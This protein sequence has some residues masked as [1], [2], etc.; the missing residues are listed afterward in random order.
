VI[1]GM[2]TYAAGIFFLTGW[3]RITHEV[4]YYGLFFSLGFS[5]SVGMVL[6]SQIKELFDIRMS[7]TAMTA[8]NFFS[9]MGSAVCMQAMG[10]IIELFPN[11][12]GV[13]PPRAYHIAF[14]SCLLGIAITLSF[15]GFSKD[16][17]PYSSSNI[18]I[19][20]S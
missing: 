1:G 2:F 11:V 6:F 16:T 8:I 3:T 15:Y 5:V 18:G 9:M 19:G 12:G 10:K 13:Y 14:L 7:A 20:E 4:F 17:S